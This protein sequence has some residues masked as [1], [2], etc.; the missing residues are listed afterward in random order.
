MQVHTYICRHLPGKEPIAVEALGEANV[1]GMPDSE[2]RFND[3]LHWPTEPPVS[4]CRGYTVRN[5][6]LQAA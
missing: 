3:D 1:S 2:E 6:R 4:L 5:V